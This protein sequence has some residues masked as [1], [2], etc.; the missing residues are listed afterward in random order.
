MSESLVIPNDLSACQALIGE[1]AQT[2]E[3]LSEAGRRKD[4][5]I[6]ELQ[7][8][9]NELLQ[10]AFYKRSERY[11]GSPDQLRL[12]FGDTDEAG[13][14]AEGLAEAIEQAELIV[15]EHKRRRRS[16]PKRRNEQLP[17]H[18]P[19]YEVIADVPD[20]VKHCE[21]H[22]ER[23]FIGYDDIETLEFER[24]KLKVRVTRFAKFACPEEPACG[25]VE[26]PRPEGLIEG[27]RYDT[28]IAAEISSRSE[29]RRGRGPR[30]ARIARLPRTTAPQK[31]A[32]V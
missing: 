10:R 18:L 7:L 31:Y 21:Q 9:V 32:A 26:P 23:R 27:N 12:D 1:L 14:A 24:P 28:S 20:E 25:V 19:R 17:E 8:T 6:A 11:L 15:A 2:V 3:E 29:N 16:H 30:M 4:Q 22:G 13:D 5:V